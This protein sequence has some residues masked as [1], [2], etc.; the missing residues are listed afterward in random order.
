MCVKITQCVIHI[1]KG[2]HV[3]FFFKSNNSL[4]G[5]G[6]IR[7]EKKLGEREKKEIVYWINEKD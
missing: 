7:M 4:K 3:I 1:S 2:Y 6:K 5:M